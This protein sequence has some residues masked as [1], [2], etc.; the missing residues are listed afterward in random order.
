MPW[1]RKIPKFVEKQ[2]VGPKPMVT[3]TPHSTLPYDG[4]DDRVTTV[5]SLTSHGRPTVPAP[6][7]RHRSRPVAGPQPC[8]PMVGASKLKGSPIWFVSLVS[9]ER[10]VEMVSAALN[11]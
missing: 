9:F 3:G 4:P 5:E 1:G 8:S 2:S 11:P 7:T 6:T 10:E